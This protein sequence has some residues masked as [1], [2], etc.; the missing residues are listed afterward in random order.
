LR[1]PRSWWS[2]QSEVEIPMCESEM[3]EQASV[4]GSAE[5]LPNLQA[6]HGEGESSE[7]DTKRY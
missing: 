7:T 3:Q 5:V 4:Q 6:G 2:N 1:N